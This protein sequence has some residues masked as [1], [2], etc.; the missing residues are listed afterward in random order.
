MAERFLRINYEKRCF[1]ILHVRFSRELTSTHSWPVEQPCVHDRQLEQVLNRPASD[2]Y[3]TTED[4]RRLLRAYGGR[5]AAIL[6]WVGL[7]R[8]I[9]I[10]I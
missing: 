8:R 9:Y 7:T 3:R 2:H 10:I 6:E 1:S 4:T 5:Q